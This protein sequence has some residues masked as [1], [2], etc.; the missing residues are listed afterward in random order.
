MTQQNGLS[1]IFNAAAAAAAE[2]KSFVNFDLHLSPDELR[3]FETLNVSETSSYDNFGHLG[4]L[5]DETA[6]FLQSLGNTPELSACAAETIDRVV[7]DSLL[8]VKAD[9]AWFTLR[10][11]LPTHA[12]DIPRWHTD[13]R[14]YT[15][16]ET[17]Q[18]KI[19]TTLKGPSTLLNDLPDGLRSAFHEKLRSSYDDT[20]EE[21]HAINTLIDPKNTQRAG[22]G[23]ATIFI[24][25]SEDRAAVHS[26]PAISTER[27]FLS[28]L[29]GSHAQIKELRQTWEA[30]PTSYTKA[31]APK[32]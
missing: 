3:D 19:A 1:P 2:H 5:R 7:K 11:F 16:T 20:P 12:F 24:V 10:A 15:E 28:I 8:A 25:G 26:E 4:T 17:D 18:K 21:R 22:H 30:P 32:P 29:P 14:F 27:I 23:Q 9:T 13:G 31:P 6:R